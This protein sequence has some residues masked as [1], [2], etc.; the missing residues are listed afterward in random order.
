M[1]QQAAR[2]WL[3][4]EV[5]ADDQVVAAAIRDGSMRYGSV[6]QPRQMVQWGRFPATVKNSGMKD[7]LR[8]EHDKKEER[9]RLWFTVPHR[10]RRW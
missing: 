6:V 8:Q 1:Q 3:L 2:S 9:W 4:L 7:E 5:A 10:D